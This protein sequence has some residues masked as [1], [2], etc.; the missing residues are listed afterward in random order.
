MAPR[1]E[2]PR[3]RRT[4]ADVQRALVDSAVAAFAAFGYGGASTKEIARAAGTSETSIYRHFRSKAGL[5]SAAV[6]EPFSDL[7]DEYRS[8]FASQF[9]EPWDDDRLM[10]EFLTEFYTHLRERRQAVIALLATAGEPE[11]AE[12]AEAVAGRLNEVFR[13]LE[14]F[15]AERARRVGGYSA[16][17]ADVWLRLLAGMVMSVAVFDRWFVPA[18]WAGRSDEL[19]EVMADMVLHG[20]LAAARN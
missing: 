19:V 16:E 2:T 18:D 15:A 5:F 20:I 13:A 8:T 9:D 10:R 11:A 7:L 17:R 4:T 14:G 12:A 3:Q 1:S 6:V